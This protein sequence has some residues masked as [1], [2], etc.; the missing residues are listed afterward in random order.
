MVD[1]DD[2]AIIVVSGLPRSGTSMMMAMLKA[3]GLPLSCD[4]ARP[5]D[6]DNP[7]GYFEDHRVKGIARSDDKG[8]LREVRGRALKVVS[9]LLPFLPT[10]ESY[11][12]IVMRRCLEELLASQRKMLERRGEAAE[13]NDRELHAAFKAE[14]E[15]IDVFM[16]AANHISHMNVAFQD[17]IE[18]RERVSARVAEFVGRPLDFRAMSGAVDSSLHRNVFRQ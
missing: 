1:A 17:A 16:R 6:E 15:R 2:R 3:G 12:V 14:S 7:N 5:Q 9:P 10:T 13:K 18:R 11:R 8:W 4:D